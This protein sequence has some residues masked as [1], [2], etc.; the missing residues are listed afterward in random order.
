MFELVGLSRTV[1]IVLGSIAL[2]VAAVNA[3]DFFAFQKGLSFSIPESAKPGIYARTRAIVRAET[4][5]A[6]II[7]AAALAVL[8]NIVELV[9]TAGLPALHTQVLAKQGISPGLRYAYLG[10]Y[11]LAVLGLLLILAPQALVW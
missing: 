3:K 7:G 1:Q 6:A 11:N 8:V 9:C 10:L 4:L 2:F 5:T